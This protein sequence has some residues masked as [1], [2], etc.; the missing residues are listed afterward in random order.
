MIFLDTNILLYALGPED[1]LKRSTT[2]GR[3]LSCNDISFSIQVFQE[4]Y[5]Q[6]THSRRKDPLSHHEATG[7]IEK[8]SNYPVQE[9]TLAVLQLALEIK[10]TYQTS[11]WDGSILAAANI[12]ECNTVF[13]EDLNHGQKYGKV[14]VINPFLHLDSL[15]CSDGGI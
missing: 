7:L 5:V 4:F 13:S 6:A 8:L 3:I 2:A 14:V 10:N 11:F 15:K 12:L 9:N 1:D